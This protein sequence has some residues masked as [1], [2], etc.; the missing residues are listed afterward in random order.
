MFVSFLA[1]LLL[2]VLITALL[3]YF[4]VLPLNSV[5]ISQDQIIREGFQEQDL[6]WL[7][8]KLRNRVAIFQG[9]EVKKYRNIFALSPIVIENEEGEP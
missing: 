5:E 3:F 6:I 4:Y 2:A 9:I 8:E 7:T 1:L